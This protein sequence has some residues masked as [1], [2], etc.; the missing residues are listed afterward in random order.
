M[1]SRAPRVATTVAARCA[2]PR[3]A[4]RP[5]TVLPLASY[6]GGGGDG[7]DKSWGDIADDSAKV[8]KTFVK[9]LGVGALDAVA[10]LI[11]KTTGSSSPA[12][13]S[14]S[15][16]QQAQRAQRPSDSG[17]YGG[18]S[19]WGVARDDD[20]RRPP[21]GVGP[22]ASPLGGLL[23]GLLGQ[24]AK[25]G[26]EG[27][28]SAGRDASALRADALAALSADPTVSRAFGGRVVALPGAASQS[29]STAIINGVRTRVVTVS[30]GVTG[31]AGSGVA[32]ASA[33]EGAAGRSLRVRVRTPRGGVLDVTGGGGGGGGD[34]VIDVDWREV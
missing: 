29:A 31:P 23:G 20:D 32:E 17:T 2:R 27:L 28:A 22:L 15:K 7:D 21:V 11:K 1:L 25:A 4:L 10:G 30:F 16:R 9:K 12:P 13:P 5:H 3:R 18:S 14:P 19:G 24:V 8:A 33:R 6:R 26:L 34:G